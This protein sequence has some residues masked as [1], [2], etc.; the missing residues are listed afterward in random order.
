MWTG[1]IA[2]FAW[3]AAPTVLSFVTTLLSGLFSAAFSAAITIGLAALANP[4]ALT[5]IT[6][7][8]STLFTFIG[9]LFSSVAI[10]GG[11][12][13]ASIAGMF[14]SI[15]ALISNPVG[16]TIIAVALAAAIGGLLKTFKGTIIEG[17][18]SVF[19]EDF[20]FFVE[21]ILINPFID[22]YDGL[23]LALNGIKTLF[24]GF[25]KVLHGVFVLDGEMFKKGLGNWFAGV[26]NILLGFVEAT[27][28]AIP[29][30]SYLWDQY[31]KWS[32]ISTWD[33][34]KD[35][36]EV[37]KEIAQAANEIKP[38]QTAGANFS[39]MFSMPKDDSLVG[40]SKSVI[41][42]GEESRK[43]KKAAQALSDV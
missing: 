26:H 30:L 39:D 4:A 31:K 8:A 2:L 32:G 9:G 3:I 19:G 15:G 43:L 10:S 21:H 34:A 7:A 5:A 17:L 27:I 13:F 37:N 20:T 18:T 42:V 38:P 12:L 35:A 33:V 1:A 11:S 25:F 41:A 28:G 22:I 40:K 29:G 16:W 24:G 23:A 14:S 6:T 36:K